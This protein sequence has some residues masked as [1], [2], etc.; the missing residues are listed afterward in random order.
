MF[1]P[2]FLG[3]IS[4]S[5]LIPLPICPQ[6]IVSTEGQGMLLGQRKWGLLENTTELPLPSG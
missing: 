3:L 6:Y 4:V 1:S 5:F 2:H